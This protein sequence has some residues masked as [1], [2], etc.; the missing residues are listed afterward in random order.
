MIVKTS[1][2]TIYFGTQ[3]GAVVGLG[4]ASAFAWYEAIA[5]AEVA[6]ANVRFVPWWCVAIIGSI[7]TIFSTRSFL[8]NDSGIIIRYAGISCKHISWCHVSQVVVAPYHSNQSDVKALL[9]VLD[10][11][12]QFKQSDSAYYFHS[13]NQT[14][15][16]LMQL[17]DSKENI[18]MPILKTLLWEHIEKV[19]F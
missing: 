2:N 1:N 11:G 8:L 18:L 3:W 10:S 9:I 17:P 6:V 4:L 19:G 5:G 15:S 7:V 16:Y 13:K 12:V 14:T